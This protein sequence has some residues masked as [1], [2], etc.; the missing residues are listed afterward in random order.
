MYRKITTLV[1]MIFFCVAVYAT[2]RAAVVTGKITGWTGGK[3]TVS[4]Q[5]YALLSAQRS[6]DVE[7]DE[8]GKFRFEL[9]ITGPTRAFL[10]L[11]STPVEEQFTLKKGDGQDTTMTTNTKRPEMVFLYLMPKAKQDVQLTLGDI[12]NSLRITGRNNT[13]S[14]YL[15]VEDWQFNQYKDKHLKNYFAYV[16]FDPVQYEGYVKEREGQRMEFFKK[17]AKDHKMSTHLRHVSEWTI[18]AD[19]IMAKMLYPNMRRTYRNDSFDPGDGYYDF[20]QSVKIDDTKT[21]KGIAYFYF[22]D[23]YLKESFKQKGSKGDYFDFV[24]NRIS[25]RALYE[26]YAFALQS[27]FK[28]KLYEKFGSKSPYPDLAKRVKAKYQPMEGML[29]GNPAPSVI[30][31]DTTGT[32]LT[33]E[34]WRGK[35]IYID[36]WATWCGPCIAEIPSL[37]KLEHDYM[38]KNVVF[39]SIS[40]DRQKDRQKWVDFVKKEKL[41]GVQVWLDEANNKQMAKAFNILQIPRF[42]LLD[43]QGRIVDA[44]A[45]RPSDRRIRDILDKLPL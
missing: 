1:S 42:I 30:L 34:S 16:Q 22:L 32:T 33:F 20:L 23:Y 7:I 12:Q 19:A 3:A 28:R 31:Q 9:S 39:V 13:D 37:K 24:A 8:D 2:N 25:D 41:E 15:N 38:D 29:E 35:Y 45:P 6:Q 11:G 26:Y 36:L 14:Y 27:N 18:Y 17:Y 43:D 5:E 40:T 21:D 10:M 4:Y 44:N